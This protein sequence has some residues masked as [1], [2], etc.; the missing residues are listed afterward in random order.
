MMK[1]TL[2]FAAAMA[3]DVNARRRSRRRMFVDG[4]VVGC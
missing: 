2:G 4:G 3:E 1:R